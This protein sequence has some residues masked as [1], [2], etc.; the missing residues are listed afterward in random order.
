VLKCIIFSLG[1]F[2]AKVYISFTFSQQLFITLVV[3]CADQPQPKLSIESEWKTF[4]PN[5]K[6]ILKCSINSNE[7]DFEWFNDGTQLSDDVD[8]SFSGNTLTIISA[9]A[10][11][12][13]Q[14]SCRGKHHER[15]IVTT[16]TTEALQLHIHGK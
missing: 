10:S 12:S 6:V 8:L 7:W 16:R 4:Y 15:T 14:Y 13:G 5:E 9:K 1:R 11:H 2:L 3:S